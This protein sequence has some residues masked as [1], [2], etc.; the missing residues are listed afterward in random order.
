MKKTISLILILFFAIGFAT[1][2]NN[3]DAIESLKKQ[4]EKSNKDIEHQKKSQKTSTWDKRGKLYM[5]AYGVNFKYL[6]VGLEASSIPLLGISESTPQA[7]YGKYE[8]SYVEDGLTVWEYK[9]IKIYINDEGKVEKWKEKE[10]SFPGA[11]SK[12][13]EAY[14]KA[15]ELDTDDKYKNKKATMENIALLREN[16][17]N[18]A[19]E[20]FYAEKYE[21]ALNDIEKCIELYSYPKTDIDTFVDLGAYAY[22]AGI[23][24]YNAQK[25][26]KANKYFQ[27]SIDNNY[28]IGTS[29]QYMAQTLFEA[30]D[31]TKAVQ[32]LEEGAKKYP[33]EEKIIY[34]L[35]DYYTPKGEFEK[36]IAYIDKAI[37]MKPDNSVLYI[38]KGNAYAKVFETKEAEYYSLLKTADSLDKEAFKVR[39]DKAKQEPLLAKKNAILNNEVPIVENEMNKYGNLT[40]EAYNKGIETIS[41][42]EKEDKATTADYYYTVAYFYYKWA[43]NCQ[44]YASSIRKIKEHQTK[45]DENGEQYLQKSLANAEK[46]NKLK[47]DDIYTLDLLAKIYFR[48]GEREKSAEMKAKIDKLQGK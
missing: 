23:F 47:P 17:M 18:V 9:R 39:N 20:A 29:Y 26:E 43:I 33:D 4:I 27:M 14:M 46:S 44:T 16:L 8:K 41:A 45:L 24:A 36:A 35:I 21:P 2:Q 6:A 34:S 10:V 25:T 30:G 40:V 48:T 42:V 37:D 32:K 13:Y 15:M 1:A 19:V 7:Y 28:E 11:L 38:V 12:S 22:Y 3:D 31:T 5:E